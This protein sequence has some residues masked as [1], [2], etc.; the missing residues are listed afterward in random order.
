MF[1]MSWYADTSL[2]LTC[3]I[4]WKDRLAFCT[5]IMTSFRLTSGAPSSK[6]RASRVDSSWLPLMPSREFFSSM[7]KSVAAAGA[8]AARPGWLTPAAAARS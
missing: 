7:A 1:M 6:S 2:F 3:T 4:C 8:A 5:E